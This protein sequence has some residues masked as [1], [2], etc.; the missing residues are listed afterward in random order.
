MELTTTP[1]LNWEAK[2]SIVYDVTTGKDIARC[3][4]GGRDEQ[5]E[6]YS[7]LI[8]SAPDMLSVLNEAV[9]HAHVYDTN[10]VLVELFKSVINKTKSW[11]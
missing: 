7:K 1:P 3:D 9:E 5:T 2:D 8:A 6:A 10:P 11:N 4:I